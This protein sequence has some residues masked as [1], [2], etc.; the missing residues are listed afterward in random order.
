MASSKRGRSRGGGTTKKTKER[1]LE[2]HQD[3]REEQQYSSS[4]GIHF[5]ASVVT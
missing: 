5:A 2:D 4:I 1:T 3:A